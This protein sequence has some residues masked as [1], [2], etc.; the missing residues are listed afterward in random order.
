MEEVAEANGPPGR[1]ETECSV[2]DLRK[3]LTSLVLWQVERLQG[4][5]TVSDLGQS[6]NA[7]R[8]APSERTE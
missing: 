1:D 6:I 8:E 7:G 3:M 5:L 2:V 4:R